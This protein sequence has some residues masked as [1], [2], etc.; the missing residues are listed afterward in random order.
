MDQHENP[1]E[2][3]ASGKDHLRATVGDIKEAASG[4]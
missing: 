1:E 4:K 2:A 3:A